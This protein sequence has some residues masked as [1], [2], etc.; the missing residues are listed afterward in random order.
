MG[1]DLTSDLPLPGNQQLGAG[2]MGE[3]YPAEDTQLGRRVA[4]KL[5][6]LEHT[7]DE[8]RLRRLKQE[9][10]A[11]SALNHPHILAIHEV[12]EAE[13]HHFIEVN[14]VLKL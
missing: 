1:S 9:A 7:Q 5:L 8:G 10:N 11:A 4:L 13:G 14:E 6:P 2:G 3:V 12:G